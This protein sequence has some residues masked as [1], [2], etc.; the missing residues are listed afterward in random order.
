MRDDKQCHMCSED[1][2]RCGQYEGEE[3]GGVSEYLVTGIRVRVKS[4]V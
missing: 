2:Q 4:H 1:H 3:D